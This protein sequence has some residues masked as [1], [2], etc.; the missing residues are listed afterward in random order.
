MTTTLLT[1]LLMTT[2]IEVPFIEGLEKMTP[3]ELHVVMDRDAAKGAIDQ[4]NWP[5]SYPYKPDTKIRVA[6]SGG[7]LAI[8]YLVEGKDLR[9]TEME[10]GGHS[11]EDSCCEFF[12]APGDG[13]YY[14]VETTCIGSVL[15]AR[16]RNRYE[17]DKFPVEKTGRIIR[18]STLPH[19]KHEIAGEIV[20]WR[21]DI[22]IPL[23]LIGLDPLPAEVSC[24]FYKCGDLTATPHFVSWSPI[25]TVKP[26]FHLPEFFGRMIFKPYCSSGCC[27][28]P[29]P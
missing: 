7:Y 22:L 3:E 17:R 13:F 27:S 16:G 15:M 26:D 8:S 24:N 19:E 23:D 28:A 18:Y 10:D 29:L 4:V 1:L 12:V 2:T 5:E 20:R 21:L 9:A 6:R 11:W 25:K 14:N